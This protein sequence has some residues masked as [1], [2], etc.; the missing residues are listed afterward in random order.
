MKIE[1]ERYT[2]FAFNSWTDGPKFYLSIYDISITVPEF[3]T[4]H[5]GSLSVIEGFIRA[6]PHPVGTFY[7][8][9][10]L[11]DFLTLVEKF[12]TRDLRLMVTG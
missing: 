9:V 7:I 8:N 11:P 6:Y 1:I 2:P 4:E 5:I 12:P 10:P 3:V